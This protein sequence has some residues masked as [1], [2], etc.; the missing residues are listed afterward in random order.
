MQEFG[1]GHG[2]FFQLMSRAERNQTYHQPEGKKKGRLPRRAAA[3][4]LVAASTCVTCRGWD[5][6]EGG[7]HR[8]G[9]KFLLPLIFCLPAPLVSDP[10]NISRRRKKTAG[11][12]AGGQVRQGGVNKD[13]ERPLE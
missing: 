3:E 9:K 5:A 4:F 10:E 13:Q 11:V 12:E 2:A 7:F 8:Q 6:I 1:I